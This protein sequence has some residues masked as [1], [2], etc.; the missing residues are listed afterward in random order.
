L[1]NGGVKHKAQLMAL[2]GK[3]PEAIA[4]NHPEIAMI[5]A[6]FPR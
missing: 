3:A 5:I 1:L 2:F 6:C 4:H